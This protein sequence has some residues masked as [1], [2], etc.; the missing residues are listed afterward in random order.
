MILPVIVETAAFASE[1]V[2]TNWSTRTQ[3]TR[4]DYR[5]EALETADHIATFTLDVP[6][7]RQFIFPDTVQAI[8][9]AGIPGVGPTGPTFAGALFARVEGNDDVG[10]LFI[11]ARTSTPGG[12]GRYGLFYAAV[13]Q[14]KSSTTS[15]WLCGLQQN[16]ENRTN[17]AI[18]NTGEIDSSD[19]TFLID[20]YDGE[21][22]GKADSLTVTVAARHW[23]QIGAILA[24]YNIQQG[25]AQVRRVA[26]INPFLAYSVVNDG[27]QPNQRSGDGAFVTSTP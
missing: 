16:I 3:K 25:Y 24:P 14:G 21:T 18:V 2:V 19:S 15:A 27:S 13:P 5:A 8:R 6:P 26:G 10:G 4:F 22:G 17:L 11:C 7:G 20:L 23:I 12:G 1:L 9:K